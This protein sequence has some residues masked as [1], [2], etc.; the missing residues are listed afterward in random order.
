MSKLDVFFFDRPVA[1][2]IFDT[3]LQA[4]RSNGPAAIIVRKSQIAFQ[5][6]VNFALVWIPEQ[7]LH[8][9]AAPLVLTLS[10]CE[11]DPSPRWKQVV[12]VAAGR[13]THHLELHSPADVDAEVAAWLRS[14]WQA[15]G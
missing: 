8:H 11:R 10:L 7:Y 9:P 12:E 4:I 6:R 14:A 13:F 5:R 3:V 1:R 15:A 2:Q